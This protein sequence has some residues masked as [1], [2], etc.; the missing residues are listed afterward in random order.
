MRLLGAKSF[1]DAARKFTD[2][3]EAYRRAGG[4]AAAE[5]S[6]R[7]RAEQARSVPTTTTPPAVDEAALAAQRQFEEAR[8]SLEAARRGAPTT[9]GAAAQEAS[10]QEQAQQ[11]RLADA[12][13]SLKRAAALYDA[14]RAAEGARRAVI[15]V[16]ERYT[17]ALE[18][19]D[20]KALK[21]LWPSMNGEQERKIRDS[22]QFTKSMEIESRD[23]EVEVSGDRATL[24]CQR[25]VQMVSVD[26]QRV[27]T[28]A[29]SVFELRR[30]NESWIIETIE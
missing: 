25:R 5:A 6:R 18:A 17:A 15:G 19:K 8:R 14:A 30:R 10:A 4:D 1:G 23:Q 3:A 12:A 20:L 13:A 9:P 24:R 11:G 27:H 7:A 28:D 22:F 26:G 21:T 29:A 2:A 16:V